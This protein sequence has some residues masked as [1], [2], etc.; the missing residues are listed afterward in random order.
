MSFP[1]AQIDRHKIRL[2]LAMVILCGFS[3][4]IPSFG[5]KPVSLAAIRCDLL[6]ADTVHTPYSQYVLRFD[7]GIVD[8]KKSEFPKA[9]NLK[10][11][12][13]C[14]GR[15]IRGP[16]PQRNRYRYLASELPPVAVYGILVDEN[17]EIENICHDD[18]SMVM[19]DQFELL[20]C[21][22][23]IEFRP[24]KQD[25]NPIP[26]VYFLEVDRR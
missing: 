12:E 7:I 13:E 20:N 10:E 26:A 3:Y 11:V 5:Q 14:I 6:F 23:K 19:S 1:G 24:A 16:L 17:G 18:R 15:R 4:P 8:L 9:L 2:V 21:L 22:E 25:R